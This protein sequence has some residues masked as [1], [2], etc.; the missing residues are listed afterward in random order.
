MLNEDVISVI[1][2]YIN[3]VRIKEFKTYS[4]INV[5][6]NRWMFK[7]SYLKTYELKDLIIK[8]ID[9]CPY[10]HS[11]DVIPK[12]ILHQLKRELER[13]YPSD[14]SDPSEPPEYYIPSNYCDYS[15]EYIN[16]GYI[17]KANNYQDAVIKLCEFDTNFCFDIFCF[18]NASNHR[19]LEG[20]EGLLNSMVRYVTNKT[21]DHHD[22]HLE[23]VTLIK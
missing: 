5:N 22:Y 12:Y 16:S 4:M 7:L 11:D 1:V 2:P 9:R 19:S 15:R 14:P 8:F 17:I 13:T 3:F 6:F 23:E 20:L 21:E 10:D 18:G